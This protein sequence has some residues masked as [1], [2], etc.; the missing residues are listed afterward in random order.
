MGRSGRYLLMAGKYIIKEGISFFTDL[1]L[2]LK[3]FGLGVSAV[4]WLFLIWLRV[5]RKEKITA[6]FGTMLAA[7]LLYLVFAFI[8][9]TL[10]RVPGSSRRLNLELFHTYR[11]ALEGGRPELRV[12][13]YNLILLSPLGFLTPLILEYRCGW[14][15]ILF[16]SFL[17][18]MSIE[19]TQ[20][21]FRLGLMEADDLFHNC[22]GALIGYGMALFIKRIPQYFGNRKDG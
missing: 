14:R 2:Y 7:L 1:P 4:I 6:A 12:T 8:I 5:R 19:A 21:L 9:T 17:I 13:L 15:D 22:L 18:S 10:A 3:L 16:L 11:E 20:Y